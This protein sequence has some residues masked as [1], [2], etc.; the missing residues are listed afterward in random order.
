MSRFTDVW[1]RTAAL[2]LAATS[3]LLSSGISHAQQPT[4]Q[5]PPA[6][7]PVRQTATIA[8]G[9]FWSMEA[10][11]KQL[12]GVEKVLPGYAGGRLANPTYE[13]VC[14]GSTGHAESINVTFDPAVITFKDLLEVMMTVRDPTTLNRQGNDE[15]NEYRS[16]IFY[17]DE[18]QRKDALE[19][20]KK[21]NDSHIWANRVVTEVKPFKN[22]FRAEDYHLDYYKK[23]PTQGY[24]RVVIAPEIAEFREKF[25]EKLKNQN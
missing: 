17:R 15:G 11:F 19:M 16:V 23:H 8:A 5:T 6:A 20:I 24:C 21:I 2:A 25:H 22:F 3:L 4:S 13:D 18:Q 14:T 12:K 7:K 9:C 1:A 10:I